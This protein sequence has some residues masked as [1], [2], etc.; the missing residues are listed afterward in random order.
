[1]QLNARIKHKRDTASNWASK[2]PI[3]LDGEI[4]VVEA[5]DGSIRLKIGDGNTKYAS[6]PFI[7]EDL[8]TQISSNTSALKD[9]ANK[10]EGVHYIEGS[11]STDGVWEGSHNC[12]TEY[13][14]GLIVAFKLNVAGVSGGC[15]LNINGLGAVSVKRNTTSSI[16][17][18]YGIGSVL[19]LVYTVDSDGTAYWKI[20][21]YDS[22][23]KLKQYAT[24]TSSKYPLL[25]SYTASLTKDSTT[26]ARFA[27]NVTLQPS[28]GT[29]TATTFNGDLS[30]NATSA[31][32]AT[33]DANG[34]V[35]ADT[36]LKKSDASSTYLGK[37]AKASSATV[38]DSANSVA[39]S[40][41][42]D[43]PSS[44][45]PSAH[46]QAS[47]TITS[48]S[49]YSKATTTSALSTSDT[50]NSALGKLEKALDDKA[51]TNHTHTIANITNLQSTLDGKLA[52]NGTAVKATA[53][54]SGNTIT[55]TYATKTE[56][57][58]GLKSKSDTSHTHTNESLGSG[59]ATNADYAST[60]EKKVTLSNFSLVRGGIVVI[61]FA[62]NVL[63][64]SKLNINSTG[65]KDIFY[66][67]KAIVDGIICAG[68][69]ATF[70]YDGTQYNV[71][72]VD[73]N[74]FYSSLVPYGTKIEPTEDNPLDLNCV[75]YLKVGNYFS[76]NTA[77]TEYLANKPSKTAFM[78]QVS[79]PLAT[80]V[81][82][83][84]AGPWKY[85][86]RRFIGYQ[87]DE[88]LSYCSV[89]STA[90]VWTY[91]PWYKVITEKDS[92][93]Q[94]KMGLLSASDKKKLDS[95]ESGANAYT[96]P[97][98]SSSTLGGVKT[99]STV[100][101]TSG[102]TACP[103][104]SGVPY[105]KD[106]NLSSGGNVSGHI[107]LTG[108]N[109]NSS[110][111]NTSQIVFGTSSNNHVAVTSN[112]NALV[113]N[114]TTSSTSN[115]IVLYL[116]KASQFPSGISAN[117]TGNVTG[118]VTGDLSGNATSATSAT[119]ATKATKDGSGN[120]ITSTYVGNKR[121]ALDVDT[122]YDG[123]VYMVASGTNVPSGSNYG[124]VLG[125]PYR[126][127][128]GNSKPDFGGQIFIPNGDDDVKPNSMFF[129]TSL[130]NSWN[131][132]QEVMTRG[133]VQS[134]TTDLTAGSSALADG[135]IY[136]VYE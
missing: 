103:I 2:N 61:K 115:Q 78:M 64:N 130:A 129:R 46:N 33:Q 85:R 122:L 70:M 86:L 84:E 133:M 44:Y 102:L 45:T 135:N 21:D 77:A 127:L 101:S 13:F 54:A 10:S 76:S 108:A 4:I 36:Y 8:A 7:D 73:R 109:E 105:Y 116:D 19:I 23:S 41:V 38:A 136:L 17:T 87:G 59:Y 63:A 82:D 5:T 62:G 94:S 106:T 111:S 125:L 1:M 25:A 79:A 89:A 126:N 123:K 35:I 119:S 124:V 95:I 16:T 128:T 110:T 32:K 100:T 27:S 67:G 52:T 34:N 9:K 50:L 69:I 20:A 112:N 15:T 55:S 88:Y 37:T 98:A 90:G 31:T 12:I 131:A 117:I 93:T 91:G 66:K 24:T 72:A 71:L 113:I 81:D 121:G 47:N 104:I 3:L 11:G 107:Y 97:T 132:W 14:S 22:D 134:S 56:L 43:K 6:L 42:S 29:I 120:T 83:E 92:A 96:L 58:N 68:E 28:T 80:T 114:P 99:T 74:R 18:H 60:L 26:Y 51:N 65:A 49:G 48:L 75:E 39:W 57:T 40:N 118:N 30:G 53:D